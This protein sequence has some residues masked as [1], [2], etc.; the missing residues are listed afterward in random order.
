MSSTRILFIGN[1]F[2][3]RNDLP[4]MIRTLAASAD[5]PRT[6]ETESSLLNGMALKTHWDKGEARRKLESAD[7]DYVSLQE[8]STLPFKNPAKMH[9]YMR[10]FD[11][12]IKERGARAVL[13]LTWARRDAPE[14]QAEITEAYRSIGEEIGALVAPVGIAWERALEEQPDLTLHDPDQSH[15]NPAGSYLA[16]CVFYATLFG[17]SPEGRWNE[18]KGLE[19]SRGK[20]LQQIAWE[21][22]QNL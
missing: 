2:T 19:E 18:V 6:L 7:W 16:A 10:K 14:R 13:Y 4:G 8:Q 3:G 22:A 11:A 15:P 17:E 21:T 12:A 9:D 20:R 1:S 5:P